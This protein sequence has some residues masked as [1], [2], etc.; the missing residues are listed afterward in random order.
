MG[1]EVVGTAGFMAPEVISVRGLEG[2]G[3]RTAR[4]RRR[5]TCIRWA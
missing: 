3:R 2:V 1:S 4:I 5:P